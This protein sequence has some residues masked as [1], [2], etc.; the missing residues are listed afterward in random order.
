MSWMDDRQQMSDSDLRVRVSDDHGIA[1]LMNLAL[2]AITIQG[3]FIIVV[4]G[5]IIQEKVEN[6]RIWFIVTLAMY[7]VIIFASGVF[8][9]LL[10]KRVKYGEI[11]LDYRQSSRSGR[12]RICASR[13]AHEVRR[14]RF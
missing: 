5:V 11:L 12:G 14:R 10:S 2:T 13:A 4:L 9:G 3:A 8:G 1:Q 6:W 7:T